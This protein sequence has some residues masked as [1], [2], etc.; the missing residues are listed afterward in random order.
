LRVVCLRAAAGRRAGLRAAFFAGLRLRAGAFF[1]F[2]PATFRRVAL[3]AGARFAV[4]FRLRDF[5][6]LRAAI[7][8][9]QRPS[10]ANVHSR[11]DP[12]R[13]STPRVEIAGRRD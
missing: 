12:K 1:A 13:R 6:R 4:D 3:R 8:T 5:E 10:D 11:R 2:F 9:S 7:T